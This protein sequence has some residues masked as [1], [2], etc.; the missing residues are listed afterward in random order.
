M[1][2]ELV[3]VDQAVTL[4]GRKADYPPAPADRGQ[5]PARQ[6]AAGPR[7]PTG[8][9]Q[10]RPLAHP[11]QRPRDPGLGDQQPRHRA[12]RERPL[13]T[14]PAA[15]RQGAGP[16][17]R[18]GRR[19]PRQRPHQGPAAQRAHA[20]GRTARQAQ[21][22]LPPVARPGPQPPPGTRWSTCSAACRP[23]CAPGRLPDVEVAAG[24]WCQAGTPASRSARC[25][26]RC[27]ATTALCSSDTECP[28]AVTTTLR[29]PLAAARASED[30]GGG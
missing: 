5:P 7:Q 21:R 1:S 2:E 20:R 16:P 12:H 13:G 14:A 26:R 19:V 22:A 23:V 6:A 11:G 29:P 4:T 18:G 25:A 30:S 27:P 28:A 17:P 8:H 24:V 10:Q 3:T 9:R 15:R